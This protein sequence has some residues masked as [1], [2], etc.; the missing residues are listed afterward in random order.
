MT[1]RTRLTVV[2]AA[3]VLLVSFCLTPLLT[4]AGWLVHAAF[5]V[6]V[7][8][9]VGAGVRRL[10]IP[11]PL[12][13]GLQ[14]LVLFYLL[15]LGFVRSALV[16][17][18]LP[19]PGSV[20]RLGQVLQSGFDDISAYGTPAPSTP[21]LRL[22]LVGSVALIGL[23]VD[24][25]A[26][27]YRRAALAG[28]PLLALYSVGTGLGDGGAAWLW[29]LL[30]AGGYLTVLFSDGQDRLTRWGRVFHG[31]GRG[32]TG[33]APLTRS[34]HRIGVLALAV[35]LVVPAFL[36]QLGNGLVAGGLGHGS[37]KGGGTITAINPV[38]SLQADL[39]RPVNVEQLR[40]TTT[41][42]DAGSMYIRV[43]VS[44]DFNGV[45]WKPSQQKVEDVPQ[46]LPNPTGLADS[47]AR[48][49]VS[50]QIQISDHLR[51]E[52]LPMPYPASEVDVPGDWRFEPNS[53]TLVGDNGQKTLGLSYT[54]KSLELQPTADQ[55]RNA[56][57]PPNDITQRYLKLPDN[58][59]AVVRAT[60]LQVTRNAP[61]PYDK[62]VALQDWFAGSGLFTYDTEVEA[63]TGTNA[64]A[65]FLQD[66]RGF[67]VHFSATMAAMARALGIPAR[68]AVGYTSG[69]Q[70]SDSSW[71]VGSK[72]A[73]AWPEL[74]FEGAGWLR[75]EPT[76][77]RG[78]APD[79][80]QQQASTAPGG[81]H[82]EPAPKPT[83]HPSSSPTANSTCTGRERQAGDCGTHDTATS[84]VSAEQSP[85]PTVGVM[86]GIAIGALLVMLL[87]TP[88]FWRMRLRRARLRPAGGPPDGA[89]V[90][91]E[92]TDQQVLAAWQELVDSAWDLGIAPDGAETPRRT[93]GRI[94]A[95][96]PLEGESREA[97][98]RVALATERVLYARSPQTAPGLDRDVRTASNGLRAAAGR[99]TRVRAVLLPPSSARLVWRAA[100]AMGAVRDKVQSGVWA[101]R[102]RIADAVGRLRR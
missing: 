40:Y 7:T 34:G 29:F 77:S 23:A 60:A 101:V 46:V 71:V 1:G 70:Q 39:N 30:A 90:Q 41:S 43:A 48:T 66:K 72:D 44:D 73:H 21:G 10:P 45:D 42:Q 2:S 27:T 75:F 91:L 36:P 38:V 20:D 59:P 86:T 84:T 99:W 19:G 65:K 89:A 97:A 22:I 93:V 25:M 53:R 54:V 33:S 13:A 31:S 95:S 5:L 24:A 35:A 32:G 6:A 79:Y 57:A 81:D 18:L 55:L 15:L 4:G 94:T 11:R 56:P 17:G 12:M 51:Q 68:V 98:G 78:F 88:M 52:W 100:D 96:A 28:L 80:T 26:V 50:T 74:Y 92:L 67:C 8:A 63:G 61:T 82:Q 14:L 76:P 83:A 16:Y 58:L 47:V 3:A 62:A 87:L 64:I 85:W 69:T 9:G 102:R 49:E 37:G